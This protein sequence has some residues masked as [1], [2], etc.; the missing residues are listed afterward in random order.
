M[1]R[2]RASGR[3][4]LPVVQQPRNPQSESIARSPYDVDLGVPP[5]CSCLSQGRMGVLYGRSCPV[6]DGTEELP[7]A[8]N[9]CRIDARHLQAFPKRRRDRVVD[10]YAKLRLKARD[11]TSTT[12]VGA[13]DG[14]GITAFACHFTHE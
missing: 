14:C 11:R 6:V 4:S 8:A 1:A 3:T 7:P 9:L 13:D 10:G 2:H 12:H 5:S